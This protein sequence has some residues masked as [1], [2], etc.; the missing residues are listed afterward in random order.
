MDWCGTP[1]SSWCTNDSPMSSPVHL[2]SSLS[3]VDIEHSR[4]ERAPN[5][6]NTKSTIDAS[7]VERAEFIVISPL[8]FCIMRSVGMF[9][10]CGFC[11]VVCFR[12]LSCFRLRFVCVGLVGIFY[13][14]VLNVWFICYSYLLD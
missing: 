13:E 2:S 6:T 11:F 5:S 3:L 1:S 7:I 10:V 12:S 14:Y 4:Y 9:F 8:L